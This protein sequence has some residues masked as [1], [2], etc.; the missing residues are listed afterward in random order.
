[1][2]AN[3]VALFIVV[4]FRGFYLK[5]SFLFLFTPGFSRVANIGDMSET[6]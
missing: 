4:S 5:A 1:M 6:V 3:R 2:L